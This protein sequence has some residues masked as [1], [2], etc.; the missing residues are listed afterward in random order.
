LRIVDIRERSIPISRYADASIPSGGLTTSIAVIVTDVVRHGRPVTGFGFS[1]IGRFAQSGLIRERFAPRLLA[2]NDAELA[3][4]DHTN[5]DPFRAWSIMLKG[6]KPGGHP[7]R[8]E[9]D[10]N[11]AGIFTACFETCSEREST[12][13]C[14]VRRFSI[15]PSCKQVFLT[16]AKERP[17]RTCRF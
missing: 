5:I 11:S 8:Q 4:N 7:T 14:A 10:S 1:S 15:G 9:L 17:I 16:P 12:N 13:T 2:A 3:N 6:E